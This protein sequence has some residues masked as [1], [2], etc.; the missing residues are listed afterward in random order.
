MC[1]DHNK[2]SRARKYALQIKPIEWFLYDG[3]FGR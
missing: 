3:K 1:R 2:K